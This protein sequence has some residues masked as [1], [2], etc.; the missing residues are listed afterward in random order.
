MTRDKLDAKLLELSPALAAFAPPALLFDKHVYSP[1]RDGRLAAE[2]LSRRVDTVVV[3]G[4]ETEVCVLAT[5]LGAI[6]IG[7]R[8]IVATDAVC[9]SADP[10]HDAMMEIYRSRYGM[11]VETAEVAEILES[12]R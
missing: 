2:L 8:T 4:T 12:V 6:D 7:F 9:S 11:Q 1:W 10:T 3:S 5:V